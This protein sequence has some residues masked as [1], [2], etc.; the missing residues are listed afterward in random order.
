MGKMMQS[1]VLE[2]YSRK[3]NVETV[4]LGTK[5]WLKNFKLYSK[6]LEEDAF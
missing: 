3:N 2:R 6:S 5:M 1:T 4:E